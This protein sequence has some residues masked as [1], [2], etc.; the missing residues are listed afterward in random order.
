MKSNHRIQLT[1]ELDN[2]K[3]YYT[4]GGDRRVITSSGRIEISVP[5]EPLVDEATAIRKHTEFFE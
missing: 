3:M 1:G 5:E 4:S 2:F